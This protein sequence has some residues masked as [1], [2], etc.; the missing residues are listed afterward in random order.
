MIFCSSILYKKTIPSIET[1]FERIRLKESVL[2]T[3]RIHQMLT[4]RCCWFVWLYRSIA[5]WH[6]N[7]TL[8]H[9][10]VAQPDPCD[11]WCMNNSEYRG[12]RSGCRRGNYS[13]QKALHSAL[14]RHGSFYQQ[15]VGWRRRSFGSERAFVDD[16]AQ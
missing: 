7:R 2:H 13:C 10:P 9:R 12:S 4:Q 11:E 6:P 14:A 3:Y 5:V 16:M 15:F 8:H 1:H